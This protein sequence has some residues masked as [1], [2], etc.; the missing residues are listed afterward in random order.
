M[1]FSSKFGNEINGIKIEIDTEN[2]L[3]NKR[4]NILK[5]I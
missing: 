1:D 4:K 2:Q 5:M 3:Q